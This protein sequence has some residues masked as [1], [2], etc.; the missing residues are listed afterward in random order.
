MKVNGK[1]MKIGHLHISTH[2][3]DPGAVQ[4][5]S[6]EMIIQSPPTFHHTRHSGAPSFPFSSFTSSVACSLRISGLSQSKEDNVFPKR[7]PKSFYSCLTS[8]T[9]D[10]SFN[11]SHSFQS[12]DY[13]WQPG[14]DDREDKMIFY[15]QQ[16]FLGDSFSCSSTVYMCLTESQRDREENQLESNVSHQQSITELVKVCHVKPEEE[17]NREW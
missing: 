12:T 5:G 16:S 17:M 9:K 6:S 4:L 10:D 15:S 14:D 1:N 13:I 8:N 3:K 2:P 11:F 7:T